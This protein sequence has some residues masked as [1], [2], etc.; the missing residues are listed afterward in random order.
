MFKA[1][2]KLKLAYIAMSV[3]LFGVGLCLVIWPEQFASVFC[4]ILGSLAL[5]FGVIELVIFFLKDI[6][7]VPYGY[8]LIIGLLS[9]IFGLILLL[10]PDSGAVFFSM[11]VGVFI[12]IDSVIKL[13]A[14]FE[15]KSL[16]AVRWWVNLLLALISAILGVL[17][18]VNPFET[19]MFLLVFMGI[20]LMV[21]AIENICTVIFIS[22][23][24]KNAK[25]EEDAIVVIDE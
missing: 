10:K 21:D 14:S 6:S 11:L 7:G 17:L 15:M 8:R 2:K 12:I 5:V 4:Y 16:G 18:V 1:L 13:Q 3:V 23:V 19:A 22:L 9:S 25:N 24:G 20:S